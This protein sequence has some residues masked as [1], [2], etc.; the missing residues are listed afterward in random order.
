M[1]LHI[2]KFFKMPEAARDTTASLSIA[3]MQTA[4]RGGLDRN[5]PIRAFSLLE[6]GGAFV[7]ALTPAIA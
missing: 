3:L 4:I 1:Q 2:S 6:A 5:H 7:E